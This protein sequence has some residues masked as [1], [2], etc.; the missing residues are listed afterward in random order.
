M[1]TGVTPP[2]TP[3]PPPDNT[4]PTLAKLLIVL[5]LTAVLVNVDPGFQNAVK[6]AIHPTNASPRPRTPSTRR[7]HRHRR[8][9][10]TRPLVA[11]PQASS[12]RGRGQG[13]AGV[14]G[15][16]RCRCTTR[17]RAA[18]FP[19]SRLRRVDRSRGYHYPWRDGACLG[20]EAGGGV[21]GGRLATDINGSDKYS[22][23]EVFGCHNHD[24]VC[25]PPPVLTSSVSYRTCVKYDNGKQSGQKKR[26]KRHC[27]VA[28]IFD[29]V[30]AYYDTAVVS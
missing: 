5:V 18:V 14:R 2:P 27:V 9:A 28:C 13:C 10:P 20:A 1:P 21:G 26:L 3:L 24:S 29:R 22:C 11:S 16:G 30:E 12:G 17:D 25:A 8:P 15:C 4:Q 6:L 7:H 23:Q 19:P